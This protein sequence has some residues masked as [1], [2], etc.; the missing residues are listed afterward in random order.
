MYLSIRGFI[1]KDDLER[2]FT[3][4]HQPHFG[5]FLT[6]QFVGRFEIVV[7][8]AVEDGFLYVFFQYAYL[9]ARP[10]AVY[11][12]HVFSGDGVLEV[13]DGVLGL[14]L[15]HLLL[16]E[17]EVVL[18]A[19]YLCGVLGRDVGVAEEHQVVD[20]VA[21][22]EEEAPHRRVRDLVVDEGYRPQVQAHELLNDP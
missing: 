22:V 21:G 17:L 19:R 7:D 8:D 9:F 6:H 15:D 16:D 3:D 2:P 5:R 1:G 11:L 14:D 20:V 10:Y 13:A 4:R 18:D 12:H